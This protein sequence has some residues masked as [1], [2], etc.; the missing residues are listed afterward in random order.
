MEYIVTRNFVIGRDAEV[1]LDRKKRAGLYM[2]VRP[3]LFFLVRAAYAPGPSEILKVE[4]LGV[5]AHPLNTC[6][7][8]YRHIEA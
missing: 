1:A 5:R 4:L 6:F 7:H 8:N 2:V 3:T